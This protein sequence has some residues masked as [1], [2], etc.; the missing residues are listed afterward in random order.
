M[1]S[2]VLVLS[3]FHLHH[4]HKSRGSSVGIALGCGLDDRCSRVRFPAG[5]RKFLFTTASR[6][7]LGPTQ[8]PIQL[9]PGALSLG[10]KRLG[11]EADH[12]LPSS[13]AVKIPRALPT[14]PQ[15]AFMVWCLVK[16][17]DNFT[18]TFYVYHSHM[19]EL[20][21]WHFLMTLLTNTVVFSDDVNRGS[22]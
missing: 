22:G 5:A 18:F 9:V 1:K 8:P 3:L 2:A 21:T 16:H 12:S 7:A 11:R 20:G 17:R 13:T 10:V 19:Q 15:Y 4:S 14:V 6:V